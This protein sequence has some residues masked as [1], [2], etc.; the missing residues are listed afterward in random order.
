MF[1]VWRRHLVRPGRGRLFVIAKSVSV[2]AIQPVFV[3]C[4]DSFAEFIIGPVKPDPFV[5][6]D[7]R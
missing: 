6:N 7:A 3:D 2:E 5:R 4:L 1:N